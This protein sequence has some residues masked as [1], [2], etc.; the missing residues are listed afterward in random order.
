MGLKLG[1]EKTEVR[2]PN[3]KSRLMQGEWAGGLKKRY[4]A[5]SGSLN[6]Y[7]VRENDRRKR[8]CQMKG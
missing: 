2:L 8:E 3:V 1:W 5:R 7:I 4:R 6:N